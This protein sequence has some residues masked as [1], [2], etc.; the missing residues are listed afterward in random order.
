VSA[1][2][3]FEG[4]VLRV[5]APNE[6]QGVLAFRS[7]IY[8]QELGDNGVD[9]FD[10]SAHHLVVC[11]TAGRIVAALRIVGPENR[12][13]PLE[14]LVDLSAILSPERTPAEV[15]RFCVARDY[16]QMRR[17]QMIHIGMLKLVHDF[18]IK[19]RITDLFTLVLPHLKNLY[20]SA[21]FTAT[22]ITCHHPIFG[23]AELLH[24]DILQ[25][26]RQHE[27]SPRPMARLLFRT[28]VPNIIV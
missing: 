6:R 12:P 27:H 5:A 18:S 3:L 1:E 7:Q 2:G 8:R 17:G 11:E 21:F 4:L 25:V 16:R 13:L 26:R 14:E 20:R 9:R 24:L 15:A 19:N 23:H 10:D 28:Q 22:G